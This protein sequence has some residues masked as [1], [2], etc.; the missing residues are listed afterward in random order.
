[1]NLS[2]L[3]WDVILGGF[4]LFLFGIGFMGDGLKAIAGDQLRD[5]INHQPVFRFDHRYFDYHYYA[6][7]F[8]FN[9]YYDW[10]GTCRVDDL[11]ASCRNHY[12]SQHWD[13]FYFLTDLFK[14]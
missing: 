12:G 5:Y 14:Y 8:G 1:M 7:F 6:I 2:S 11:T 3:R 9:S 10:I 4:G 13:N